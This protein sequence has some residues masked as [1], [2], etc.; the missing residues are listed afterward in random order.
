MPHRVP[1]NAAPLTAT[2]PAKM[3]SSQAGVVGIDD[4][5]VHSQPHAGAFPWASVLVTGLVCHRLH[6]LT[7]R[8]HTNKPEA[9]QFPAGTPEA[10]RSSDLNKKQTS[11]QG[12]HVVVVEARVRQ[13]HMMFSGAEFRRFPG[14]ERCKPGILRESCKAISEPG[15]QSLVKR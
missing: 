8:S 10:E 11:W 3:F 15:E 4:T 6:H 7:S 1:Q 5:H 12:L 2:K 13:E 9:V 14:L